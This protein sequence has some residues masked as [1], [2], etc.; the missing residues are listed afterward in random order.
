MCSFN[1]K[2]SDAKPPSCGLSTSNNLTVSTSFNTPDYIL[3]TALTAAANFTAIDMITASSKENL[4][5][6]TILRRNV[7][8]PT[9]S[10]RMI[11]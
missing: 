8:L 1:I 9:G 7:H 6:E 5:A 10:M 2:Q 11:F 3:S 4:P